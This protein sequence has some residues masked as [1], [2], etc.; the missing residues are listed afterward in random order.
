MLPSHRIG[1]RSRNRN[2]TGSDTC[3]KRADDVEPLWVEKKGSCSW[4]NLA[5]K[6]VGKQTHGAFKLAIG[7]LILKLEVATNNGIG[8]RILVAPATKLKEISQIVN[9]RRRRF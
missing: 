2:E 5:C 6:P 1:C 7:Q 3:P 8:K 4:W 9:R